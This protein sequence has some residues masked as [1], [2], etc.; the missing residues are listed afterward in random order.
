MGVSKDL[1]NRMSITE[2]FVIVISHKTVKFLYKEQLPE[3]Y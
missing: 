3:E 1:S 2:L